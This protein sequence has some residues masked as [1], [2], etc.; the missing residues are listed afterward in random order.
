MNPE[1]NSF[2]LEKHLGVAGVKVRSRF[3]ESGRKARRA[4]EKKLTCLI[5]E[6]RLE[7]AT[8]I[9]TG[10]KCEKGSYALR[11]CILKCRI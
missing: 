8:I 11:K 10:Q 3:L 6:R 2:E 5:K 4:G 1:K 7:L 9:K